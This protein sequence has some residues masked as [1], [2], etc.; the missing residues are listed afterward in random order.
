MTT[1]TASP[2][3]HSAAA[4]RLAGKTALITGASRGIGRAI[5]EAFAREGADLFLSAT[6][7]ANLADVEAQVA[8]GRR[9]AVGEADVADEA[10]VEALFAAAVEAFGRI[11]I[12]VNNAGVYIGKPLVDYTAAEFDRVMR[13]NAYG[14]F[15]VMQRALRHMQTLGRGKIVNIAST[16]G[17]WESPNQAAYNASK[18]A[19]VA[20]TRCA[21]L[22]NAGA[23]ITVNAIC[24]GFVETD[25]IGEFE[26]HAERA[27]VDFESFK[28][29]MVA[30]IPTGRLLQPEEIAHIAVYLASPESDGMTGQ[31]ISISGG[32][33]M[34]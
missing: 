19:V 15:H 31:T 20:L 2:A 33:R 16:A 3:A 25:M 13:V 11:D 5:A 29:A 24:P 18:H 9:V 27:G 34:G 1:E 17:K 23:G 8:A 6:A 28:A 14:T 26:G 4:G 7:R 32:M 22:E 10:D 12:V 21:A 30:R